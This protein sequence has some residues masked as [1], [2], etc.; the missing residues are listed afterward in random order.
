MN[1]LYYTYDNHNV[2]LIRMI[3]FTILHFIIGIYY[4]YIYIYIYKL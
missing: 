3:E 4:I 2:L 1:S